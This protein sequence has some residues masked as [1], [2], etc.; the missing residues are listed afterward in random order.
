VQQG[1]IRAQA[2]LVLG[3]IVYNEHPEEA[4]PLL[5]EALDHTDG[6][7]LLEA[8]AHSYVAG[9][10]DHDPQ[11]GRRSALAAVEIV[12]RPDVGADP[13]H[14]ACALLERAF[15]WLV[16]GERLA[17][18]DIDRALGLRTGAGDPFIVRRAQEL[19]E[20]CLYHQGRLEESFAMD[21]AEYER[22]VARGEVGQLPPLV[23]SMS[24]LA[25]LRGDWGAAEK[26]AQECMELVQQGEEV[27]HRRAV[28]AQSRIL[29]W[30]GDLDAAREIGMEAL[31]KE[32]AD[33]DWWEATIFCALLGFVELSVPDPPAALRYL[34]R[35][36][37]H[38]HAVQVVLPTVFRF[39]GDLVEAAVLAGDLDL[40]ERMLRER[41]EEP[42]TRVP[43]PWTLA[44]AARGRGLLASARGDLV[45]ALRHLALAVDVFDA[46]VPMPFERARTLLARGQV[47]RRAGRRRGAREDVGAALAVFQSLGARAWASRATEELGR[48]GG[49]TAG[50]SALTVSERVVAELAAAG[51]SN[52]EIAAEL[53]VS[54]RT[55]E[56]QL[57][58]AYRKLDIQSR[59]Q[60]P[61]A[62]AVSRAATSG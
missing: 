46:Q 57:S 12:E 28:M 5:L 21:Q 35:A 6:I 9:M 7:P 27:W 8:T 41:L 49:R 19:A 15:Q 30:E 54:V 18:D 61:A 47:Q 22:L 58:A 24:V 29:A 11:V 52:R 51:R 31:A 25:Q 14:V 59:G 56:S 45:E 13:D 3:E 36:A 4:L 62:L 40:A 50:G 20:R 1:P 33:H 53:V 32:E 42:A 55:V 38:A 10:S 2:L 44:M 39:D 43:L 17:R 26:Y 48:I 37:D 60:L 34:L 23:Q 16:R